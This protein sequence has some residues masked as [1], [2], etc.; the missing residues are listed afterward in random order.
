[1]R[2]SNIDPVVIKIL[3]L[4]NIALK[5]WYGLGDIIF[6]KGAKLK[7]QWSD[8][9]VF[10]LGYHPEYLEI[11]LDYEPILEDVNLHSIIRER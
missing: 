7:A 11:G 5:R 3:L 10:I 4:R 8:E 9:G 6:Y 2:Q 1:M